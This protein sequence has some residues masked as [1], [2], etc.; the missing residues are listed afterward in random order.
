ML[1]RIAGNCF[2]LGRYLERADGVARLALA[3]AARASSSDPTIAWRDALALGACLG[4]YRAANSVVVSDSAACWLLLEGGNPS[5]ATNCLRAAGA[6]ARTAR[7]LLGDAYWESVNVAWIEADALGPADLAARGVSELAGWVQQ[8]CRTVRGAGEELE[9]AEPLHAIAAGTACERCDFALRLLA[10]LMPDSAEPISA[11][12]PDARAE[13]RERRDF[14]LTAAAAHDQFLRQPSAE[15]D[16]DAVWSLLTC[17]ERCP[18]SLRANLELL[19]AALEGLLGGYLSPA[20]GE[21]AALRAR[22]ERWRWEGPGAQRSAE[23]G[24]IHLSLCATAAAIEREHF[25][26]A[27]ATAPA[28]AP[29]PASADAQ[30]DA[31]PQRQRQA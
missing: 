15:D 7:D 29:A 10:T 2:W 30:P 16:D 12:A 9:R 25:Q 22:V 3:A 8:R 23:L 24:E 1:K 27:P 5:S 28:P 17:D 13:R 11:M 19:Q 31:Q 14:I 26:P 4:G 6:N 18:R 20:L 21:V